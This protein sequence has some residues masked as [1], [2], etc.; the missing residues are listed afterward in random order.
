MEKL[1]LNQ[2]DSLLNI[3]HPEVLQLIEIAKKDKTTQDGYG[4]VLSFLLKF[5]RRDMRRLF[6]IA[7]I[8][9]GYPARTADSL[10]NLI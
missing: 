8:K 2:I 10:E 7:M 3:I 9:E 6:L 4:T 1:R 5:E